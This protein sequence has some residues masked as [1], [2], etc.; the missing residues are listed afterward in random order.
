LTQFAETAGTDNEFTMSVFQI[1]GDDVTIR[2]YDHNGEHDVQAT[3][4]QYYAGGNDKTFGYKLDEI[5]A[6]SGITVYGNSLEV[7]DTVKNRVDD[8][9]V[10][11]KDAEGNTIKDYSMSATALNHLNLYTT[12]HVYV[13]SPVSGNTYSWS[14]SDGKIAKVAISNTAGTS[15]IITGQGKGVSKITVTCDQTGD[16]SVF[17]VP[18]GELSAETFAYYYKQVNDLSEGRTYIFANRTSEG[19]TGVMAGH[20]SYVAPLGMGQAT[21][22]VDGQK[23][24]AACIG[25]MVSVV[26]DN[27]TL[28]PT[29]FEW[30]DQIDVERAL[31]SKNRA[32]GVLADK[33]SSDTDI[34]LAKARLKRALVRTSVAGERKY[35]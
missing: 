34:V 17:Y 10:E 11:V 9:G 27:V 35:F 28:V 25:G 3:K 2:R 4:G 7:Y 33:T 1:S 29:T 5:T 18:V 16:A 20:I 24:Y 15:A 26:N 8:K 22:V 12:L 21:V 32:E 6:P 23:R 13:N 31:S 19:D 30:A 14:S